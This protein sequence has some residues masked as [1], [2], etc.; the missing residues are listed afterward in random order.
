MITDSTVQYGADIM[1]FLQRPTNIQ[2]EYRNNILPEAAKEGEVLQSQLVEYKICLE[3]KTT[4]QCQ[5]GLNT[6]R[7]RKTKG[8]NE[9]YKALPVLERR[10]S[11]RA[12]KLTNQPHNLMTFSVN[13]N[14]ASLFDPDINQFQ[15][16]LK[17]QGYHVKMAAFVEKPLPH[18]P[19]NVI[20]LALDREGDANV[21]K[22]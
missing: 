1:G 12:E 11:S 14:R 20:L 8:N 2:D 21:K 15:D 9:I 19:R 6:L 7:S 4:E 17:Q 3:V 18:F 13:F 16:P 5:N 10:Q 22:I